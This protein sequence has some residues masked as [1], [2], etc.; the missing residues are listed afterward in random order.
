MHVDRIIAVSG[1]ARCGTSLMMRMLHAGGVEPYCNPLDVGLGRT[2]ETKEM[3]YLPHK[4]D[5]V[6]CC[7]GKAV[8]I[9]DPARFTPPSGL[10]YDVIWM[11]R[12]FKQQAKSHFKLKAENEV[13][14]DSTRHAMRG[15]IAHLR[16]QRERCLKVWTGMPQNRLHK[17]KFEELIADPVAVAVPIVA[18]LGLDPDSGFTAARM[19]YQV[20]KRDADCLPYMAEFTLA[21]GY[22]GELRA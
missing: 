11:D 9:M 21:E 13:I 22:R 15:R 1:L 20:Q 7:K 2:Y 19:A 4:S 10:E 16:G 18:F 17:V 3:T 8:K 14:V 6:Q 5:W 12:D